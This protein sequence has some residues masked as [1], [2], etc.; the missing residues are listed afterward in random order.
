M[1]PQIG[2]SLMP[3]PVFWQA[4][5]P[6]FEADVVE[7]VEW[8]FDMGWGG[9]S[10][11][12]PLPSVLRQFSQ[13]NRLLGH[14]V[15]YSLLSAQVDRR[16][17]LACLQA[18]CQDYAYRH[19][20]EHFGWMATRNFA[21]SAPL[22]MPLLP[23]TLKLGCDRIQQFAEIAQVPVGL[24][25]LAFAFGLQDVYQQGEFLEQLLAPVDGFLLLDL[26]NLYCQMHNFQLSAS[27][28]L[29]LYPLE[30]VRELHL[31]G[32]SWSQHG[33]NQIRRDTHDHAVPTAVFKLLEVALQKCPQVEAIILERLGD[34]L[35][36]DREQH[37]FRQDFDQIRQITDRCCSAPEG[38]G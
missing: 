13:R 10:L 29:N 2:L 32:G 19:I 7:V 3:Q 8:S 27:E 28:I 5:Q 31:S 18:E 26:H 23:E 38:G 4:V 30:R 16:H 22:P 24:E 12:E 14:G 17:W 37:Q 35:T 6:L 21:R 25:N 33:S 15:S 1:T 36:S 9:R 11:P 20:S 34:T